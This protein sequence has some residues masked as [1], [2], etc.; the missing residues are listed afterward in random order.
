MIHRFNM[1]VQEKY[2]GSYEEI[3]RNP[4]VNYYIG[5]IKRSIRWWILYKISCHRYW[6]W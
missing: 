2:R 4:S 6:Q 3:K 5:A 1:V